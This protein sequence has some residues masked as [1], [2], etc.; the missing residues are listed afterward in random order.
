MFVGLQTCFA[1]QLHLLQEGVMVAN[2]AP[3]DAE[4]GSFN[5]SSPAGG[6]AMAR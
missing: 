3:E 1:D 4:L 5:E 6:M 2:T